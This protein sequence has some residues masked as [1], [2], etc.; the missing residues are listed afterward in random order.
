MP[1]A[2]RMPALGQTTDELRIVAWLK[3][4][5]ELV[6][7]GEPLLEVETDKAT[8]QVEA[9]VS[10]TLL[11]IATGVDQTVAAGSVIA[12]IG[13][14]GEEVPA[15][16]PPPAAGPDEAAP[17]VPERP[18]TPPTASAER[19]LATPAAR[20]LARERGVDLGALR[21]TGPGG[22]VERRDVLA[23]LEEADA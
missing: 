17:S 1:H 20:Q 11:A 18:M 23:F 14:P 2:V 21:G 15:S 22:V 9:A 12:Y 13:A 8:L 7:R 10:G 3:G 5:G 6:E 19:A 16:A 4:E